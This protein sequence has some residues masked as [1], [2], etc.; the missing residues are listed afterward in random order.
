[1]WLNKRT[2]GYLFIALFLVGMAYGAGSQL[3]RVRIGDL[4][5]DNGAVLENCTV[6]YRLYGKINR[7][8]SNIVLFPTWFGGTTAHIGRVLGADKLVDTTRYAVIAVAALGNGESSTPQSLQDFLSGKFPEFTIKDMVKAQHLLLTRFLN[9]HHVFAVVGGSMGGMQT[10][11]WMVSFP[12]FMDRAVPY[13]GSPRLTPYDL[14]LLRL[15]ESIITSGARVHCPEDSI[16]GSIRLIQ[17]LTIRTPEYVNTHT[18]RKEVDQI[19]HSFFS[20]AQNTFPLAGFLAQLRAMS[21]FD[22]FREFNDDQHQ[23]AK[24]VKA[25]TLIIVSRSDH[26]VNP[27]PAIRFAP[28]IHARLLVLDDNC[29]HLAIGCNMKTVSSAIAKFLNG[30]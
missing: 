5:L 29:G 28:L 19:I 22:I 25:K 1:M 2:V 30:N 7:E 3:N 8:K 12:D 13:V 6:A 10:F 15:Q 26:T 14:Y 18:N 11:Q 24:K 17:Q 9:I 27:E 16:W 4:P 21:G 20:P 23:A